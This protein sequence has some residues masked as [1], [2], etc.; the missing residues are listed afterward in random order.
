ML[1]YLESFLKYAEFPKNQQKKNE[2]I[3]LRLLHCRQFTI[4]YMYDMYKSFPG[5]KFISKAN[6]PY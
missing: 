4:C 2:N 5:I 3:L 6:I 1:F